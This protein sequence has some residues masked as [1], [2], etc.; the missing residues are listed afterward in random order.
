VLILAMD[1]ETKIALDTIEFW[2]KWAKSRVIYYSKRLKFCREARLKMLYEGKTF[3][4][5][6]KPEN[7]I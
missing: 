3:A 7:F 4:D 2:E 6:S 1:E 5:I